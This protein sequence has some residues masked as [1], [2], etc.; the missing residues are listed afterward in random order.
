MIL[1]SG[2]TPEA[3]VQ[4]NTHAARASHSEAAPEALQFASSVAVALWA[5]T[6][7][8]LT[9]NSATTET[10]IHPVAPTIDRDKRT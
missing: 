6:W 9:V 7:G 10:L 5:T 3:Q 2:K 4:M 1:L 8:Y